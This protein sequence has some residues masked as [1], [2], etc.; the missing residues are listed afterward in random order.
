MEK[1]AIVGI[2]YDGYIDLWRDFF[3]LINKNWSNCPYPIYVVDNELKLT[4]EDTFGLDVKVINAG[5]DAE[6]SR[7]VQVAVDSIQAEYLLLLLED[8]YIVKSVDNNKI[9]D[10]MSLVVKDDIDYYSMPMPE[11]VDIKERERYKNYDL[12]K[13]STKREYI[14]SCQPS[15]WKRDFLKKCIGKS[16]Y[17]AWVFEGVYATSKKI[18]RSDFLSYSILDYSN[19]LNLRHG[20]IQGKMV[21]ETVKVIQECGYKLT[22]DRPLLPKKKVI[23]NAMKRYAHMAVRGMNL[24]FIKGLFKKKSILERYKDQINSVQNEIITDDFIH[25]YLLQKGSGK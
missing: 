8:F 23:E 1:L 20:A 12:Y 2:F 13:I 21:P 15:I 7:K 6:Y 25:D 4:K 5:K 16:N 18:R 17:N 14:F 24:Q 11:F 3:G 9:K 10:I 22:S 19:P